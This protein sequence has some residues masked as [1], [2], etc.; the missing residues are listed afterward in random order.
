MQ[1]QRVDL[2][3]FLDTA[4]PASWFE[5]GRAYEHLALVATALGVC[6]AFLNQLV[7]VHTVRTQFAT[8]LGVTAPS[9]RRGR[10]TGCVNGAA[11]NLHGR[12]RLG[13]GNQSE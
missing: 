9:E 10:V 3:A 13:T 11:V 8:W 7:E 4:V 12:G 5:V 1:L 2:T 6:N